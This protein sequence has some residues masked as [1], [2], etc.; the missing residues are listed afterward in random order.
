MTMA[1]KLESLLELRPQYLWAG[2]AE[3]RRI[4]HRFVA[5]TRYQY[6]NAIHLLLNGPPVRSDAAGGGERFRARLFCVPWC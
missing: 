5:A 3:K 4:L 2:N 1:G 6:R